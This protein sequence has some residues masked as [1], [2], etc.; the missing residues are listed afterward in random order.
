M[1]NHFLWLKCCKYSHLEAKVLVSVSSDLFLNGTNSIKVDKEL[2]TLKFNLA[3]VCGILHHNSAR[4]AFTT[5]VY[6]SD[7]TFAN[8]AQKI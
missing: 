6:L 2:G 3:Q 4:C 1:I 7:K 8:L 5:Y